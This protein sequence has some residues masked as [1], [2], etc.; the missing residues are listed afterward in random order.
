MRVSVAASV[1]LVFFGIFTQIAFAQNPPSLGG[2]AVNVKIDEPDV[3]DGDI[4][5]IS[6]EGLKRT[7]EP[8]DILMYGVI[9]A[10]PV[11]SVAPKNEGTRALLSSG[12]T[13]VR[14]TASE[15]PI[16]IGDFITS[17]EKPGIGQ[18]A[19]AS[20]YV[21]GKALA[22]WDNKEEIGLVPVEVNIGFFEV[23]PNTK[24]LLA[25]LLNALNLALK[26]PA[27]LSRM[28]RYILAFIVGLLTFIGAVLSFIKF[29]STGLEALGR[30]PLAR[31]TIIGGMVAS[32]VVVSLL[33]IGG[34][35]VAAAIIILGGR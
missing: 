20:G 7:K 29:M 35:G 25:S 16:K 19:T 6:K 11:L 17:S 10:S 4:I 8:Y 9:V 31:R 1:T 2:V 30:N 23:T 34:F 3:G 5:S 26:D 14:V 22:D 12:A 28:L 33:A 27:T 32:G 13:N 15:N 24:S 18:K 21:L